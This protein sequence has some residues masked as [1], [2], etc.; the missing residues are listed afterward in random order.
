MPTAPDHAA[1][2]STEWLSQG[3]TQTAC[4]EWL[5]AAS[6]LARRHVRL[7]LVYVDP[8][9]NTGQTQKDRAGSYADRFAS[10]ESY[11]TWLRE[12][13]LATIPLMRPSASLLV[14]VDWRTS[15]RV[16]VLLDEV[17]GEDRF[18]NHLVWSYG[19]GGSSP[20]RFARKHDDILF[21]CLEPDRY[22]FEPPLV[23]ATSN[24]L[25]GKLKKST[26]V[27]EFPDVLDI[28]SI[29]NQAHERTGYPTQKPLALL[30]MLIRACSPPKGVV[31]DP[32]CGSGT[33]VVAA[34][35][36]DRSSLGSDINPDALEV[37]R[38]RLVQ[39]FSSSPLVAPGVS[40][41]SPDSP[42]TPLF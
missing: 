3:T 24:R 35:R 6:D 8:P 7:D 13:L 37:T 20:R 25:A 18:V 5:A 19:L 11:I 28:P 27:V 36:L 4:A 29:N 33:T 17:L 39:E 1:P 15:H 30:G 10:T 22:Y 26:D 14:H 32:C 9:F 21:Y 42:P 38:S 31:W 23:P 16:R 34:C 12:R 41:A 40:G 2:S